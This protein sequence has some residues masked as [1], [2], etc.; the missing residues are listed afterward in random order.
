MDYKDYIRDRITQLRLQKNVSEYSMS[1]DLGL[2]R[3]YIQSVSS[4]K[5]LPSMDRFL[6]IC[7]Y[8]GLTPQE[9]FDCSFND[10]KLL[11]TFIEEA[12]KLSD[13]DLIALIAIMKRMKGR[14]Q[15]V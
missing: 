7:E 3:S 11:S 8:F 4:G 6:D 2:N 1:L 5:A 15:S 14:K 10:P 9:F 13:E 12:K